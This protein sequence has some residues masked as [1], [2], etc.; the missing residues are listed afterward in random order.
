MPE[1]IAVL[2]PSRD[3]PQDLL[4]L[5]ESM[6]ATSK[7][8]H[9]Y[10]YADFDQS[11]DYE[12]IDF[13]ERTTVLYG[14]RIGPVAS[15]NALQEKFPAEVWGAAT[16]DSVFGTPDWDEWLLAEFEKFP[17]RI[18]VVSPA[19]YFGEFV[20]FPYVS[21]E[22]VEAAG[23]FAY[24]KAFHFIWDTVLEMLGEATNLVYATPEQFHVTH[25]AK[26]Q[27]NLD[28]LSD[29]YGAYLWWCV[30]DRREIV[31]RIRAAMAR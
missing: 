15:F 16:D 31:Q 23:F 1:P 2:C 24:P 20:N 18:G 3:R 19:H 27:T 13:G 11:H 8:T 21:K 29:D 22:W 9:L 14:P 12:G 30:R 10:A 28:H 17:H 6:R 26:L 7:R 25:N 4:T 5:A